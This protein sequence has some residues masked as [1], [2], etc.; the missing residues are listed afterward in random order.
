[1]LNFKDI[2]RNG[3]YIETMNEDNT[4]CIYITSIVFSKKLI[5]EKLSAFSSG[6]YY[7]NIKSI[8]SYVVVNQ[9]FNDPKTFVL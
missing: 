8:K 4:E 3:Y 1:M 5:I 9:K 2:R 6:L 7:A